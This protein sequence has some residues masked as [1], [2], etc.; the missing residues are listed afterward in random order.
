MSRTIILYGIALAVLAILI[1]FLEFR[2]IISDITL[3]F[4]IGLIALLFTVLGAWIGSRLL[5]KKVAVNDPASETVELN[6]TALSPREQEV[7]LLMAEGYSNQEI[8]DKLFVSLSTVK[9][10]SASIYFKLEV[11]RRTQAVQKAKTLKI[12]P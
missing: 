11:K 5:S 8:A 7:L 12:I 1:K 6:K 4:Y 2:F 9:T 10:H 3:E